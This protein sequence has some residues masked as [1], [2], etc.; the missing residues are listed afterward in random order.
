LI[1]ADFCYVCP[2][3]VFWHQLAQEAEETEVLD[4]SLGCK[5]TSNHRHQRRALPVAVARPGAHLP[6]HELER[7][8]VREQERVGRAILAAGQQLEQALL[9]DGYVSLIASRSGSV[10]LAAPSNSAG[11]L[12]R[13]SRSRCRPCGGRRRGSESLIERGGYSV[14]AHQP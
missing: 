13:R 11:H 12:P 3:S 5:P 1:K 4:W 8:A 7:E 9:V 2:V 10:A 14:T 6:D